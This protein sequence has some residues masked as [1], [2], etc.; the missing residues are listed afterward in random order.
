MKAISNVLIPDHEADAFKPPGLDANRSR[1]ES[2]LFSG[3]GNWDGQHFLNI[4]ENGYIYEHSVAFFPLYPAIVRLLH[5]IAL[6]SI[7]YILCGVL[8]NFFLFNIATIYLYKLSMIVFAG[9]KQLALLTCLFYSINPASV[10]FSAVYTESIYAALTLAS[11]FYLLSG[12][13]ILATLLLYLTS[14]TRSNGVLNCAY[15]VYFYLRW[16]VE[17]SFYEKKNSTAPTLIQLVT[18]FIQKRN[19]RRSTLLVARSTL[20]IL[21][22][23]C[24]FFCFQY[25]VY[26]KFC[27]PLENEPR[28]DA[29][30]VEYARQNDFILYGSSPRP[31]WYIQRERFLFCFYYL[32][33]NNFI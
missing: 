31:K 26:L 1:I 21:A 33:E 10:F 3:L 22:V 12:R 20:A 4:A 2:T 32:K 28:L 18:S 8:L 24:G 7:S 29:R 19:L 25:F 9:H 15:F 5:A 11:L 17:D 23:L 13:L 16:Y 6:S 14:L 30:L 27:Q